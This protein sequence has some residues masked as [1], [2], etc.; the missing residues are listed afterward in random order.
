MVLHTASRPP[1]AKNAKSRAPTEVV[2]LAKSEAGLPALLL[3]FLEG[4][5]PLHHDPHLPP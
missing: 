4:F 3:E 1:F 5:R 2:V